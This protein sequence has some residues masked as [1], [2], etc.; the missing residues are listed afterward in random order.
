[1]M[2]HDALKA[3]IERFLQITKMKPTTF[4][5]RAANDPG[6]VFDLRKGREP[7]SPTV[8]RVTEFM[9]RPLA[10]DRKVG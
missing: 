9:S 6:F 1:M 4:G 7:R 5:V 10:E 3:E 8:R 2:T